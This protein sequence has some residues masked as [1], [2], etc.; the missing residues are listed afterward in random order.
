MIDE[1]SIPWVEPGSTR[2]DRALSLFAEVGESIEK[3]GEIFEVSS[4]DGRLSYTVYYGA[5]ESCSCPNH[6]Y[7]GEPRAHLLAVGISKARRRKRRYCSVEG[8]ERRH[9]A[10]GFC[11]MHYQRVQR[12]GVPGLAAPQRLARK[13]AAPQGQTRN[14][15]SCSVEGCEN[16]IRTRK[17]CNLHYERWRRHGDALYCKLHDNRGPCSV[18]GCTNKA[19]ALTLCCRHYYQRRR[20]A[21]REHRL[22]S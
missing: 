19:L 15:G 14:V 13:P 22:A 2:E 17:M 3:V 4:P 18:V 10:R 20:E 11:S 8:C 5:A 6:L 1:V 7:R 21:T 12:H 16:P 9:E